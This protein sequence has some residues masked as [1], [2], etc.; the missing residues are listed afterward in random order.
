MGK[1]IGKMI[2][3]NVWGIN[4]GYSYRHEL[5][6]KISVL[7]EMKRIHEA[8]EMKLEYLERNEIP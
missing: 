5:E 6:K 8:D 3:V 1:F 4:F 2:R 7:E